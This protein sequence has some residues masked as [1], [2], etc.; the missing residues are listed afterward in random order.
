[1]SCTYK[2]TIGPYEGTVCKNL[3]V[4]DYEICDKCHFTP[5]EDDSPEHITSDSCPNKCM[6]NSSY[7]LCE[8]CLKYV[9]DQITGDINILKEIYNLNTDNTSG[10][11][12][13]IMN[14]F[15]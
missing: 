4:G 2:Y 7:G 14:Q 6:T 11:F 15:D 8:H 13:E 12:R 5:S 1:M 9:W 3:A 10:L